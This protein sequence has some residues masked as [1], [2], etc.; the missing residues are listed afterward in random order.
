MVNLDLSDVLDLRCC[1]KEW[2]KLISDDKFWQRK[3]SHNFQVQHYAD[4]K[5]CYHLYHELA[6]TRF[7][8]FRLTNYVGLRSVCV[9]VKKIIPTNRHL[10]YIDVYDNVRCRPDFKTV[11]Y[12]FTI[13]FS[14]G[15]TL[16]KRIRDALF[17]CFTHEDLNMIVYL[18]T[19]NK[20]YLVSD[21]GKI[22]IHKNTKSVGG[23]HPH[24]YYITEKNELFYVKFGHGGPYCFHEYFIANNVKAALITDEAILYYIKTNGSLMQALMTTRRQNL[25][26]YKQ[27]IEFSHRCL[28]DGAICNIG[29]K[30]KKLYLLDTEDMVFQYDHNTG[31]LDSELETKL[32]VRNVKSSIQT[33]TS[34][35]RTADLVLW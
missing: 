25:Q 9:G 14:D 16:E 27:V 30:N 6:V 10:V 13:N 31:R 28:V 8:L 18:S 1:S 32:L 4:L 2:S 33:P 17:P 29:Y 19:N 7:E 24:M 5:S 12:P 11:S 34:L 15:D 22:I 3:L 20:L 21:I 35:I 23:G 26:S